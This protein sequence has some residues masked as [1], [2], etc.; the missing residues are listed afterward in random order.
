MTEI[1]L[2]LDVSESSADA[3]CASKLLQGD[4]IN[5][6]MF[7][8]Y[9]DTPDH[10]LARA[11]LSLRIRRAGD[12]RTQTVKATGPS[13]VGLFV[14]SEWEQLVDGSA[15]V[16]DETTPVQALLGQG[17]WEIQPIFNVD[18]ERRTWDL[19]E[20]GSTIELALDRGQVLTGGRQQAICE[21]ELELTAGAP[22]ALFAL[23]R[24]LN[25]VAPI[26]LGVLTK[27]E[28]GYLLNK[29]SCL[30]VKAEPITLVAEMTAARSFQHI[31]QNCIRQF[32]LN[33]DVLLTGRDADALHQARVALRRLRSA[34]SIFKRLIAQDDKTG[35]LS[36]ELRWLTSELGEAR[37]LDV[38]YERSQ[39]GPFQD[40]LQTA[41]A[42]AYDRV[43]K[44]LESL[45]VRELM[46][47]LTE[48][49]TNGEWL[50]SDAT[51]EERNVPARIFANAELHRFRRNVKRR[52]DD[53]KNA[54]D[55]VR[56]ALRKEAKKLRYAS[57]FF[58]ALFDAKGEIRSHRR[59]S[60]ALEQLQEYLGSLND[61]ATAPEVIRELG[62]QNDNEAARLL[63]GPKRKP[64]ILSAAA[65]YSA[66]L[67]A[68]PFWR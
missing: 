7:A 4:P 12:V 25:A 50:R 13:G 68:H 1:E 42:K 16:L 35:A 46:L 60:K 15:P 57:E 5:T 21:I 49:L 32:R 28:R 2:K 11:N 63:T 44:A 34:F 22:A 38:L 53:L 64:L 52:G 6:E 59:F 66:L 51:A 3:I 23:A 67:E 39:P 19:Q 54:N 62:E 8:V 40:R 24:R 29:P 55:E 48:W 17:T 30:V 20:N 31:A 14:R 33:E 65:A 27:A 47:D 43:E 9:F 45:R 10:A 37:N 56:H 18:V 36:G 58:V 26:R 41:R 61:L